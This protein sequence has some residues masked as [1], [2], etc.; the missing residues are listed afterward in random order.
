LKKLLISI[1]ASSFNENENI[2]SWYQRVKQAL[3][4]L[5]I[6]DHEIV[7]SDNNSNDGTKIKLEKLAK[8]DKKLKVIFNQINN[9]HIL[10]PYNSLINAN[11][12]FCILIATDLEDPPELIYNIIK[13]YEQN[14]KELVL[15]VHPEREIG[16]L[17]KVIRS[18]VL[19]FIDFIVS[20]DQKQLRDFTGFFLM[21]KR[22]KEIIISYNNPKPHLRGLIVQTGFPFDTVE[23]VKKKREF[24]VSKTSLWVLFDLAILSVVSQSTKLLRLSSIFALAGSLVSILL[25]FYFIIQKILYWE[26]FQAGQTPII[27]LLLFL[28][29]MVF[30]ILGII[31]E[32]LGEIFIKIHSNH[33]VIVSKKINFD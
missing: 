10:S 19:G 8:K 18:F 11:G 14:K 4:K 1:V 17:G 29:S 22:F 16:F 9:G 25:F 27:L 32:Y 30:L 20:G 24:G 6:Y 7:I 31:S 26:T 5:P 28:F 12:D 21:T 15:G 13:K 23:Y 33:N 2:E 3:K